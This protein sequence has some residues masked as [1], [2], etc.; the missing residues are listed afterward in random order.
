MQPKSPPICTHQTFPAR[1]AVV[2]FSRALRLQCP[3]CGIS[4]I[5]KK[6]QN[7]RTLRDWLTPLDQCPICRYPYERE[8]GYFLLATWAVGYGSTAIIGMILF[9]VLAETTDWSPVQILS[10]TLPILALFAV[11]T[12]RNAKAIFLALDH[13]CDPRP[14]DPESLPPHSR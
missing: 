14:P 10:L 6:I 13:F 1:R 12:A 5:F 7:V 9:I 8:P 3:L 2:Y 4:P 11:A